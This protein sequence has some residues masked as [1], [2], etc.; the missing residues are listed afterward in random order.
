MARQSAAEIE[1]EA[2]AWVMR[3]DREGRNDD[4]LA[5]I[6]AWAA[7]DPRRRGAL[8]QA[9]AA[10]ALLDAP[11]PGGATRSPP[12][13]YQPTRR[14]VIAGGLSAVAAGLAATLLIGL[15]G[16][17][18]TTIV[19]EIRRVPLADGSTA[20]VNSGSSIRVV[21]SERQRTVSLDEGE[22][23]FQ[24]AHDPSRPFEVVAGSV[25]VRA[26]GTA[27]SVR[28]GD[29]G[30]EILV[31]EGTVAVE[32]VTGESGA[33]RIS[34]GGRARVDRDGRASV[35]PVGASGVDRALAWRSGKI[36]LANETLAE[37]AAEFNRHNRRAIVIADPTLAGERFH[38]LFRTDDPEGFAL[39]VRRSLNVPV[40]LS[41][42]EI[43]IG[44]PQT[45]EMRR[46]G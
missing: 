11:D 6:E 4:L 15:Q 26:I 3:L 35:A 1:R 27:F 33:L 24:V 34:A 36:D 14:V 17:R 2:V 21:I 22:A 5:E 23:W 46:P 42:E 16:E 39:S 7:A 32:A 13:R 44:R 10:W 41:A 37:A 31:S 38:G 29:S 28:R 43:R 19:G 25:R 45:S 9:E 12:A 18:V 20:A 40:T 30:T 8:L